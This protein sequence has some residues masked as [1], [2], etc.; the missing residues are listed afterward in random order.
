MIMKRRFSVKLIAALSTLGFIVLRVWTAQ[1]QPPPSAPQVMIADG[2]TLAV[3]LELSC[4]LP[5]VGDSREL[6][7]PL[8]L[9]FTADG[10]RMACVTSRTLHRQFLFHDVREVDV[11]MWEAATGRELWSVVSDA[12]SSTP[13]SVAVSP[14]GAYLAVA[15]W[16]ARVEVYDVATGSR[17]ATLPGATRREQPTS[18]PTRDWHAVGFSPDSK[19][20]AT[21]VEDETIK[22]WD[23]RS[24]QEKAALK[25]HRQPLRSIAFSPDGR[26]LA[27]ASSDGQVG[28]L[29]LWDLPAGKERSTLSTDLPIYSLAFSA[30]GVTLAAGMPSVIKLWDVSTGRAKGAFPLREPN[31]PSAQIPSDLAFSPGGALLASMNS[32]A[33]AKPGET[34]RFESTVWNAATGQEQFALEQPATS[35]ATALSADWK[36]L[37]LYAEDPQKPQY[38]FRPTQVIALWRLDIGRA[39]DEGRQ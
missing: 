35:Y 12:S 3:R 36:T 31:E 20:L 38:R 26:V 9:A 7:A 28:E 15:F 27:S 10:R 17:R 16:D 13:I 11:Q 39:E 25:G 22:L 29:K 21:A 4:T 33:E 1:P 8:F 18:K 24:F 19:T 6:N 37:A 14:D 30:D 2:S 5:V 23:V 34:V 32:Q